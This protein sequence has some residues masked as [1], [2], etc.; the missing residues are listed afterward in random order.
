MKYPNLRQFSHIAFDT[1]TTGLFWWRDGIFGISISC[2]DGSDFYWD[3]RNEPDILKYLADEIPQCQRVVCHNAKFDWHMARESGIIFPEE[4]VDCTLIRAALIDE[5]LTSYG[6]DAVASKYVGIGKE[7]I[8]QDLANIFGG[9]AEKKVQMANLHRAP[10]SIVGRYAK[11]DT[12]ATLKLWEWQEREIDRQELREVCDLEMRLL[13]VLVDLEQCGVHVDVAGAEEA[14]PVLSRQAH[15][16]QASLNDMAGFDINVN[17]GPMVSRLFDPKQ[18]LD[19]SWVLCDGT[20]AGTTPGGKASID[21]NTLRQMKH[22]AA[23]MILQL[24]KTIKTR[25]TFIRGHILDYHHHGV[26]HCN[27]NQTRSDN[28]LG[29]GTGRLSVNAPALQQIHKR[30][31]SIASVVRSLFLPDPGCEWVCNDWAQMDF[32]VFAHYVNDPQI[33]KM[34]GENP[35]TDF[36][37]MAADLTGLPR[38]PRFS[39]DANAKQINLGLVFGMGQGKLAAEMRLPYTVEKNAKT[40]KERMVP[41]PEAI[42]VFDKYHSAIPGV[43]ELLQ[44]ASSKA[45]SRGFVRTIMGRRIRFPRGQSTHKAGGLVFQGSAAD[46]LKVKLVELHRYLKASGTGAR[47]L[48]NV[49]DEFDVSVP[50]GNPGV[51]AEINRILTHFDG[52][53]TPIR[54]RVPIRTDQGVGANWWEASK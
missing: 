14:V 17:S 48:L 46:A 47:L 10:S 31:K 13:P 1:E 12:R 42:A 25:D 11:Q 53:S 28:D 9:K 52:N 34:Y 39:G 49:H 40:G 21:A 36:H 43:R 35:D 5:H 20:T 38:S 19:G 7:D 4:R 23:E 33:T 22:P 16:I 6:L 54:F 45:L 44:N 18:R 51:L 41:G 50:P 3:V 37:Q 8:I 24:R 2:P 29:T 26:I 30:D 15:Q 32:R 27:F